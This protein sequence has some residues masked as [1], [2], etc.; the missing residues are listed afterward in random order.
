ME[1]LKLSWSHLPFSIQE[2]HDIVDSLIDNQLFPAVPCYE[3]LFDS[4]YQ[5]QIGYFS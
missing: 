4:S 1:L 3:T 2:I 5:R